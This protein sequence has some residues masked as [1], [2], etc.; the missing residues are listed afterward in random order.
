MLSELEGA[1]LLEIDLRGRSTAF[2][3]RKAFQMSPTQDWSGSAGAV[4][5][6][7]KRLVEKS[8]ISKTAQ[9]DARGTQHLNATPKGQLALKDWA[10]DRELATAMNADPFRTRMDYLM[11]M[12]K[13]ERTRALTAIHDTLVEKQDLIKRLTE[14]EPA[15]KREANQLVST[16]LSSRLNWVRQILNKNS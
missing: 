1:I 11:T 13:T 2:Q 8:Y 6:A 16:L 4:Y 9:D 14:S 15:T 10:I 5:P 7:I 12:S 3:V